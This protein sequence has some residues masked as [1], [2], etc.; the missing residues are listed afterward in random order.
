MS[1][2]EESRIEINI[3]ADLISAAEAE[4][5]KL[6]KTV[7]EMLEKWIYLGR[8]VANQLNEE[9][10]LLVMAGTGSVRVGVS[11]D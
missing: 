3:D 8:A 2:S 9:E 6:P 11:E 5:E 10:Q 1:T 7:D 4:L